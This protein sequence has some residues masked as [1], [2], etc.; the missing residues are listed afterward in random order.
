MSAP[1]GDDA[2]RPWAE[3]MVE[4]ARN[5]RRL[6]EAAAQTRDDALEVPD[7]GVV[8][9]TMFDVIERAARNPSAIYAAQ[10]NMSADFARLLD[11]TARRYAGEDADPVAAPDPDD[12]R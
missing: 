8:A 10:A 4:A 3:L 2:P 7:P 1:P 5:A 6:R 9:K 12:R 11:A